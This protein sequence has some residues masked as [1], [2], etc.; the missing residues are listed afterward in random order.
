[1]FHEVNSI[2]L[3]AALL[4]NICDK[5]DVI[6]ELQH[7]PNILFVYFLNYFIF[8]KEQQMQNIEKYLILLIIIILK[9]WDNNLY[10][11]SNDLVTT[12][13]NAY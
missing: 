6:N 11:N 10:F 13:A 3:D 5:P 8:Y 4:Q 12:Y 1:M 2:M 9:Y 7:G